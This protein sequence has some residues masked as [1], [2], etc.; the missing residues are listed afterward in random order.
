MGGIS[1][2]H[3][4]ASVVGLPAAHSTDSAALLLLE[5]GQSRPNMLVILLESHGRHIN[6]LDSLSRAPLEPPCA[7]DRPGRTGLFD[8]YSLR[9]RLLL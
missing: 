1:M 5:H 4:S 8:T 9:R 3:A 6:S 7:K 2:L